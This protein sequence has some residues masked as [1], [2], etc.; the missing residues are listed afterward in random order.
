MLFYDV[1][2]DL[3]HVQIVSLHMPV[4]NISTSP[5]DAAEYPELLSVMANMETVK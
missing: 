5:I 2:D 3:T 4:M 1:I